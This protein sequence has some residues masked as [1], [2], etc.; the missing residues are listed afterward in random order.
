MR[1]RMCKWNA[2]RLVTYGIIG[3]VNTS[4]EHTIAVFYFHPPVI[5]VLN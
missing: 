2:G 4:G 5:T 1:A 3:L